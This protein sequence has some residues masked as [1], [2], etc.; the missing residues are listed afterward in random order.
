MILAL[1][2][3]AQVTTVPPQNPCSAQLAAL[4]QM[5]PYFCPGAYPSGL[6]PGTN[7]IPCWPEREPITA[8]ASSAGSRKGQTTVVD[9]GSSAAQA[10]RTAP[11]SVASRPKSDRAASG[12]AERLSFLRR[13]LGALM[14]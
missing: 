4:C 12:P 7:G 6:V 9:R 1:V 13:L 8:S 10:Q 5:S 14:P 11:S 3:L 2:L